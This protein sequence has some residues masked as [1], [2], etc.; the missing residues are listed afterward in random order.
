MA[1]LNLKIYYMDGTEGEVKC[2]LLAQT[3]AEQAVHGISEKNA[4]MATARMAFEALV[5]RRLI[6]SGV[7]YEEWLGTVEEVEPIEGTPVD[8]TPEV[9]PPT[10]S[11]D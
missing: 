11:S 3:R 9:Q 8:P 2:T 10:P 1:A 6:D 5:H 4:I 7:G